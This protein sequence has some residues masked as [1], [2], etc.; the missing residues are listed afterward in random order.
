MIR[1]LKKDFTTQRVKSNLRHSNFS[2][3]RTVAL[4]LR[5]NLPKKNIVA[6]VGGNIVGFMPFGFLLPIVIRYFRR[7]RRIV[8]AGFI[9]SLCFEAGQLVT[10]LGRFDV[11]DLILNTFG[12]LLGYLCYKLLRYSI[13]Y[14]EIK[15]PAVSGTL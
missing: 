14:P 1:E 3:M 5:S 9:F 8:F 4:Y 10:G 15:N 13:K 11:D 2:P 6:N 12:T 7:K